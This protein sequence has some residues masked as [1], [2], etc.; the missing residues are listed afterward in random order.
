[1]REAGLIGV[2]GKGRMA[3]AHTCAHRHGGGAWAMN[4]KIPLLHSWQHET[5]DP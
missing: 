5:C 1:M 2:E 4:L 3:E